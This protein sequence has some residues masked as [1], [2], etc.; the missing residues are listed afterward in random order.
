MQ[1]LVTGPHVAE[2]AT[3]VMVQFPGNPEPL[4]GDVNT[5]LSRVDPAAAAAA[6]VTAAPLPGLPAAIPPAVPPGLR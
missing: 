4:A 1:G 5:Q 2:P 3:K 6:T